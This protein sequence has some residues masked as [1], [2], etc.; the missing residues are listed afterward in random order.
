MRRQSSR[1][2]RC[3]AIIASVPRTDGDFVE[4]D[5]TRPD[6]CACEHSAGIPMTAISPLFGTELVTPLLAAFP[7]QGAALADSGEGQC[8]A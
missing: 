2:A 7:G 3:G 4:I 1:I 5:T 8:V 6:C